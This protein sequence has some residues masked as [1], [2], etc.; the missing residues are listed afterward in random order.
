MVATTCIEELSKC[1]ELKTESNVIA[2]FG[3]F[4]CVIPI[5]RKIVE[6]AVQ[7]AGTARISTGVV[8]GTLMVSTEEAAEQKKVL[9]ELELG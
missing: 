2:A 3:P 5:T 6:E 4:H 1:F 9:A 8:D 7:G